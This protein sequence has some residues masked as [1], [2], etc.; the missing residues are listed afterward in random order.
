MSYSEPALFNNLLHQEKT[1]KCLSQLNSST[2]CIN[3]NLAT[4]SKCYTPGLYNIAHSLI[5]C[6]TNYY[7]QIQNFLH[8]RSF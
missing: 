1:L 6:N 5:T 2:I 8:I 4:I 7:Q 3:Q